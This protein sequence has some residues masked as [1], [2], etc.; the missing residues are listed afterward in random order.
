LN[1][2]GPLDLRQA[3]TNASESFLPITQASITL[4]VNP[5]FIIKREAV[6][7]NVQRIRFL[8]DLEAPAPPEEK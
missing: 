6:L 7:V 8:G 2:T 5:T 1:Q 4:N 3:I